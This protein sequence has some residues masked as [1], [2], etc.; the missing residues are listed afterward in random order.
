MAAKAGDSLVEK[1]YLDKL[2]QWDSRSTSLAP[3]TDKQKE[4]IV[5]LNTYTQR[6]IPEK[7]RVEKKLNESLSQDDELSRHIASLD[8]GTRKI[9][10]AQQFFS[11]FSQVEAQME[12]EQEQNYR[13]YEDELLQ[14]VSKCD[15]IL[16]EVDKVLSH[17]EKLEKQHVFVSTQTRALHDACEQSLQD[18]ANLMD[19]AENISNRLSYFSSYESIK[20]R[21]N[22]STMSVTG[23][24]FL[25]L[26]KKIDESISYIDSH[27]EYKESSVYGAR[28]KQC[29]TQAL[30]L[31]KQ[32]VI[33]I[34]RN[35]SN[36]A[37]AALHKDNQPAMNF[38]DSS[39]TA[40]YGKFKT[41]SMRVKNIMEQIE[42]RSEN[43]AE[44]E[45]L[46]SDCQQCYLEYRWQLIS[47]FVTETVHK[48]AQQHAKNPCTLFRSGCSFMVHVCQDEYQLYHEYFT[49]GKQNFDTL[50]ENLCGIL[51]ETF[52]P[53]II[54]M[55][56]MET[57][58]ELCN[59]L[60]VEMLEDHVQRKAEQLL[61][62]QVIASEMLEDVQ[63][64]LVYRTQAYIHKD[65]ASYA[66]APGDLAYPD[67]LMMM[68]NSSDGDTDLEKKTFN[69]TENQTAVVDLQAMWY[70]TVRRTLVCLS[71]LYTCIGKPTFEG[72]AQEALSNCIVTLRYAS[73]EITKKK[74]AINGHLFLIKHLLILREQIT[75]FDVDF[76]IKEVAL[77]FTKLRSAAYGL[78]SKGSQLL[79]I[80]S[81]NALLEFLLEGV[82]QLTEYYI[83]SKK[84]V[85]SELKVVCEQFIT[86]VTDS[87]VAPLINLL[88][89]M[90]TLLKMAEADGKDGNALL[91]QQPF[92][93][94]DA[95]RKVVSETYMLLK[96]K[97]PS[98]IQSLSLY[99]ANK[100]TEYILFKPIKAKV[101]RTYK[102]LS[103]IVQQYYSE[104]DQQIIGSP[105]QEQVSLLMSF[106]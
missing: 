63:E 73:K 49:K 40:L 7:F 29:L 14:Y 36:Q 83:D 89:K 41:Q 3:L 56:H 66:P 19:Q 39:Y 79:S 31:V 69:R 25:P 102:Q 59:I 67:K 18:Q 87:Y 58:A 51:Y 54:H 85:D 2:S 43:N 8:L 9:E 35:A 106:Q 42:E 86:E 26:L 22:S 61:S 17:L 74:G 90:D 60:K 15:A 46:I 44:Y 80:S 92:A 97:L 12:K 55:T 75:P 23:E 27:P 100:D 20:H 57:L 104:E 50:M 94:A 96:S 99:L 5:E 38:T 53:L 81:N 11:W 32:Y 78:F 105:S 21:L 88:D 76:A 1:K 13:N 91:K 37:L 45:S 103:T 4:S 95:I 98:T 93:K 6:P 82:P 48:F 71:K 34:L 28:F 64:R 10:N 77:D 24:S 70:P 30:G 16:K 65:I 68:L 84:E 101:L 72:I 52:R 47:P 62:F 33:N